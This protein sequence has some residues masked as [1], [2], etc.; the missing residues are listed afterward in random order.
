MKVS[1]SELI[2]LAEQYVIDSHFQMGVTIYCWEEWDDPLDDTTARTESGY[3]PPEDCDHYSWFLVESCEIDRSLVT[4][5][6]EE[7]SYLVEVNCRII[8]DDGRSSDDELEDD[9]P[10]EKGEEEERTVY[11]WIE[12]EDGKLIVVDSEE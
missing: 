11:V 6:H 9:E 4:E 12:I 2:E 1:E 10:E 5:E 7:T 8:T 3:A